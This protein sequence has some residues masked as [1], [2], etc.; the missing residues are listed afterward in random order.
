VFLREQVCKYMC[1]YARFQSAMFDRNTLLIAY[2]R[3]AANRAAAQAR[4]GQRARTR[5]RPAG[6]STAY[7][8]VFRAAGIPPPP[9]T[10]CRPGHHHLRQRQRRAAAHA[11]SPRNLATASMHIC[12]QCVPFGIDIRWPAVRMHR[13]GACVDACDEVMAGRWGIPRGLIRY[14]TRTRVE[15]EKTGAGRAF[16]IYG[17]AVGTAGRLRVGVGT[18]RADREI[19][20]DA[21]RCIA[22]RD[23]IENGN[24]KWSTRRARQRM[25]RDLRER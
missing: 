8:Y 10:A 22:R 1:P 6:E 7:D 14:T 4:L 5:T 18:R 19:L 15:G 21:M 2:D 3:C 9:T 20:R 25:F 16:F 24:L 17:P 23:G 12:V 13:C 11:S